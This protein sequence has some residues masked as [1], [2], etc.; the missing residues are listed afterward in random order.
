MKKP[1]WILLALLPAFARAGDSDVQ[2]Q[3]FIDQVAQCAAWFGLNG[4]M[5]PQDTSPVRPSADDAPRAAVRL[6]LALGKLLDGDLDRVERHFSGALDR[7]IAEAARVPGN[8]VQRLAAI[9]ARYAPGCRTVSRNLDE[10]M[11]RWAP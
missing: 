11:A 1:A 3:H 7:I 4:L 5:S 9:A 8:D 2:R 10:E 6:D